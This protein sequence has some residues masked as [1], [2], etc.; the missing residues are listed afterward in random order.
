[1][2]S[3]NNCLDLKMQTTH[4]NLLGIINEVNLNTFKAYRGC[5][6]HKG[7]MRVAARALPFPRRPQAG[8]LLI[9]IYRSNVKLFYE[10]IN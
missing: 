1:M 7:Q 6:R 4:L 2:I 10:V 3:Y 8:G 9:D 5:A